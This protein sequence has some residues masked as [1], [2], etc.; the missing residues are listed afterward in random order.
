MRRSPSPEPP[1]PAH[2]VRCFASGLPALTGDT[3]ADAAAFCRAAML[4]RPG[5]R[6]GGCGP[7]DYDCWSMLA[8]GQ[9]HLFGRPVAIGAARAGLSRADILRAFGDR[10]GAFAGSHV[11]W[12]ARAAGDLPHHGDGV[13][14][15]HKAAPFHCGIYLDLDRGVIAHHAEHGGFSVDDLQFLRLAGYRDLVFHEWVGS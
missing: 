15:S 10:D 5:W 8:L 6:L 3:R 9:W 2:G 12:R 11:Q 13:L 1:G 4:A 7:A 14:M